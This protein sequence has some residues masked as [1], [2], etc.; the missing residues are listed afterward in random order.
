MTLSLQTF[1]TCTRV[2]D[3]LLARTL[4]PLN[5]GDRLAPGVQLLV[6][7]CRCLDD[8]RVQLGGNGDKADDP[9]RFLWILEPT[10]VGPHAQG[11]AP[12]EFGAPLVKRLRMLIASS[13]G[14]LCQ[15]GARAGSVRSMKLTSLGH[16]IESR[17]QY[18][19]S[20]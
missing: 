14:I 11:R 9:R 15:F 6:V 1:F 10:R 8:T 3:L 2:R 18:V 4:G 5:S 17:A 12:P 13:A 7:V 19:E 16:R 20:T